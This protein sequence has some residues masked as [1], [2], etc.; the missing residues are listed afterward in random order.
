M[1]LLATLAF[2]LIYLVIGTP[3]LLFVTR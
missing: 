2:M 1:G 3:W